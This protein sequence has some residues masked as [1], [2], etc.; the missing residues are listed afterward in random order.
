[1]KVL[2]LSCGT[3]GGH[4]SAAL[5]IKEELNNSNIEADFKEYLEITN[6]HLKDRVNKLYIQTTKH[7]GKVFKKAYR[8]GEL[9][10]KT[11]LK[12]PVYQLNW[13]NR[14]KLYNYIIENKYDYVVTTHLFPAQALTAIKKENNIHFIQIAT[15]YASI[16]FWDE[17]NPD[18]FVIPNKELEGDF[19]QKGNKKESL[20]PIG[21]PVA[22]RYSADYEKDKCR[23][24][25]GLQKDKKYVL[26]LTG[27]MGFGNISEMVEKLKNNIKDCI[28]IVST[29]KNKEV[30]K[31]L[32]D[33]YIVPFT[34]DIDVYMKSSDV[35]LSKPGGLT[36]TEIATLRK[37]FIHTMPIPGC[38]NYN[39]NFFAERK[40]S[41]K[42]EN[43]EEVI[44]KTRLLINSQDLQEELKQN[45]A[46]YINK[47]ATKEICELIVKEAKRWI[48][49]K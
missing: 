41:L 14:K 8:L 36:T 18:Y 5:A 10:Q 39:A 13:L 44:E 16:P 40:M 33:T 6:P 19:I 35:I 7:N 1:M 17:T 27:S 9:Y 46:K 45:Q 22:L 25:L 48:N 2:I 38:E 23:E 30:L 24:K 20:K 47:N 21:I 3:G 15:D 43:I 42:A 34:N 26:I 12:S 29:G 4:N 11:K 32:K 37:P 49:E 28:F 31:Q